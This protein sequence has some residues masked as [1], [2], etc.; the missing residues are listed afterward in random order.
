M[1]ILT[2]S[3]TGSEFVP[4]DFSKYGYRVM[5]ELGANRSGG[6]VTYLATD[7]ETEQSV[8]I[9]QFQFARS[10]ANWVDYS[11]LQQ[12]IQVLK[13]LD[14]P[15][16]PQYLGDFQADDGFCMVQEYKAANS[17]A[18]PRSFS[19]EDIR[20]IAI[21]CL[22]ILIYLQSRI[23]PVIHRDFKP[24]NIL[25]D[26][27]L[28]VY[29]V[30]FGFAR[31][32]DGEVG[33]SSVVK[34]TLGF[35]PPE[36]IFNRQLTEA[37]DLYGLGMT[38]IC[39]LT[40]TPA[41]QVGNLVDITYQ[42]DFKKLKSDLSLRWIKWLEKMVD[43]RL[44]NRFDNAMAALKAIPDHGLRQPTVQFNRA[45]FSLT[46]KTRGDVLTE[47]ITLTNPTP[48]TTLQGT[49]EVANHNSDRVT[50]QGEH[51]WIRFMPASFHGN[52]VTTQIQV[53]TSQ[54][55]AGES[56]KRTLVLKSNAHPSIYSFDFTLQ[57]APLLFRSKGT[58]YPLVFI[59][60]VACW[61]TTWCAASFIP[62]TEP[63]LISVSNYL[64][65]MA[66][67]GCGCGLEVAGWLLHE[68]KLAQAARAITV[69]GI[70]VVTLVLPISF[71]FDLAAADEISSV[72]TFGL[73]LCDG[74]ILGIMVG[75]TIN[76]LLQQAFKARFAIAI[77]IVTS[78]FGCLLGLRNGLALN[79]P[80]FS[81]G[82]ATSGFA[83]AVMLIYWPIQ[84]A[85]AISV[86]RRNVEQR[87]IRP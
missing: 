3:Y 55:M 80:W 35:M 40:N 65:L 72:F 83:L 11:S 64:L 58:P 85:Q 52:S 77:A 20:K 41:D 39:L 61:I 48:E 50:E 62:Q 33:V 86:Y 82:L 13:D 60:L 87:S 9:K 43:P 73:G 38:L 59:L 4:P 54:L 56:Y 24:A 21:A 70:G 6:R 7:I 18:E 49:W 10:S 34:G 44:K 23:P 79:S 30:D 37:S 78:L 74:S 22:E 46:A 14:H 81:L 19:P 32:G 53:D 71:L 66:T 8:V 76:R 25:V 69:L 75:L 12:E 68:A 17:L 29:L 47:T 84:R 67:F 31:I 63:Q 28:N 5:S 26:D 16:I 42:V 36:Q 51:S 45:N 1:T 2:D 27:N 57:T 15:G